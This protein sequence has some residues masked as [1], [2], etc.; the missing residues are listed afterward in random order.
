MPLH[1]CRS[2]D[3]RLMTHLARRR[4][5]HKRDAC[6]R[7]EFYKVNRTKCSPNHYTFI[8]FFMYCKK[9]TVVSY[10]VIIICHLK[11]EF[12]HPNENL[13]HNMNIFYNVKSSVLL[14][15]LISNSVFA[16]EALPLE[17]GYY[18]VVSAFKDSQ[19]N[20]AKAQSAQL[21]QNGF[22]SGFGMEESKH[23]VYVYLQAFNYDQYA[24]SLQRMQMARSK[25]KFPTAWILKIKDGTELKEG[26]LLDAASIAAA[27]EEPESKEPSMITEYI[28]NPTPR[29]VI[30]PQHLG[31]TPIFIS[32]VQKGTKKILN[33]TAKIFDREHSKILGSV[34]TNSYYTIQDPKSK[35]GDIILL[36]SVFGFTDTMQHMNY[37]ETE[38]D[39]LKSNVTIFGNFF[40]LTFEVDR[41]K[42]GAQTTLSGVYFLSDAAIMVP[43]SKSQLNE[44]LDMLNENPQ[45]K[46]RIEGHTNGNAGGDI[47][48][49][50]P[51]KNYFALTRDQ[52]TRKGSAKEL[53]EARAEAI[54]SWLMD[55]GIASARITTFGWGGDKPLYPES[56]PLARRNSRLEVIVVD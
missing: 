6:A 5:E 20:E 55:H 34:K 37:Y 30:K 50:G 1:P 31:N 25:E 9:M 40:M 7:T 39:T 54:K 18:V 3:H 12:N 4:V 13:I 24:Q 46:I 36:T 53:S 48:T 51:S 35:S 8:V 45:M 19:I 38:R 15:T 29:P 27:T 17:N 49:A 2:L 32:V 11:T 22:H 28:P 26:D 14:I 41:V 10:S 56:N 43:G 47:I 33:G 23:F 16:Q 21:Y 44:L 52:R 42:S